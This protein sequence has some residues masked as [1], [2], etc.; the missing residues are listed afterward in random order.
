MSPPPQEPKVYHITHVDN[1]ASIFADGRLCCDRVM[2]E[3]G[4]PA[5]MVGISGIKARRLEL[6]V[7]CHHGLRV[8]D[9]VPFYF[10]PRSVM[11]YVISCRNHPEL[12]YRDGQDEIVH[13][14]LDLHDVVTWAG[15]QE[16]RW[17]FS[18]SNAGARYT[19][20]RGHLAQ[21]SEID[22]NAVS[23]SDWRSATVK[24]SKQAEF[25]VEEEVPWT[26]VSQVG[27][28]SAGMK[29]RAEAAIATAAHRPPVALR[30]DWYY[31]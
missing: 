27:V 15:S 1:L 29:A 16:R 17:A 13:L 21:L 28:I 20:F 18:L 26:L 22:W 14:E 11:L 8:G 6:P 31:V 7:D 3:R 24:E 9:C 4:G 2:I 25:L 12:A 5:A 19:E 10:C 30:R 23:A